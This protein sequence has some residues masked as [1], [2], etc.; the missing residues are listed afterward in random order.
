MRIWRFR[1][2]SVTLTETHAQVVWATA[3]LHWDLSVTHSSISLHDEDGEVVGVLRVAWKN[4]RPGLATVWKIEWD[5]AYI[6]ESPMWE[7]LEE[8]VGVPIERRAA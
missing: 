2:T 4:P 8:L 7:L 3:M 5:P 6:D 1:R